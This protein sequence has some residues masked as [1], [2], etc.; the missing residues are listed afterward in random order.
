MSNTWREEPMETGLTVTPNHKR[1]V[2]I[3]NKGD[4]TGRIKHVYPGKT[5]A[6]N[7]MIH[8]FVPYG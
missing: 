4:R 1:F 6:D 5:A 8:M 3:D 2:E 7:D